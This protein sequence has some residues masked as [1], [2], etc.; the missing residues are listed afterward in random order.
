[1]SFSKVYQLYTPLL[2]NKNKTTLVRGP[3]RLCIAHQIL[4]IVNFIYKLGNNAPSYKW[5]YLFNFLSEKK[6]SFKDHPYWFNGFRKN[7]I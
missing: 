1:M 7:V 4:Q 2:R 5:F 3:G 6:T